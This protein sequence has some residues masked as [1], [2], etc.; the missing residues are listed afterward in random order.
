MRTVRKIINSVSSALWVNSC[1][2]A[3]SRGS[4]PDQSWI[5]GERIREDNSSIENT[6]GD[7]S[8]KQRVKMMRITDSDK[9]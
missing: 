4:F 6:Q 5:L 3:P 2:S 1:M 9:C 8:T 7:P